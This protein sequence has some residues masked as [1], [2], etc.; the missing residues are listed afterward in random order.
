M[1]KFKILY[2]YFYRGSNLNVSTFKY[3]VTR[4]YI[5]SSKLNNFLLNENSFD[6]IVLGGGKRGLPIA[7]ELHKY[8]PRL[9]NF[10]DK[11]QNV[12]ILGICYGMLLLY[13]Y[14]YRQNL[15]KLK[16][17]N[18]NFAKIFLDQR[19]SIS[20]KKSINVRFNHQYY[21]PNIKSGVISHYLV[22][23]GKNTRKIP[24]FVKFYESKY[25]IQ[26][27]FKNQIDREQLLSSIILKNRS[28]NS[29]RF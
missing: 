12:P 3:N 22:Q 8:V 24:V 19:Y 26:F 20:M 29:V 5:W 4:L 11:C 14:Y 6:L 28:K 2:L 27:H 23:N 7:S 21:C 16:I 1:G 17:R 18:E 15:K 13:H 10:L 25:G 9:Y